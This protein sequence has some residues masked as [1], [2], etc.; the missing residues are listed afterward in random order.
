MSKFTN[1]NDKKIAKLLELSEVVINKQKAAAYVKENMNTIDAI[2]PSDVTTLVHQLVEKGYA[3]EDLKKHIAKILNLFYKALN[4][5]EVPSPEETD[6]LYWLQK[7]NRV[8]QEKLITLKAPIKAINIEGVSEKYLQEINDGIE[9][10]KSYINYFTIKENLLFPAIEKY[11]EDFKCVQVMWSI[12]DDIRRHLKQL[13]EILNAENFDL[14]LFN[15]VSSKL[16]FDVKAIIFR[17]ENILFPEMLLTIPKEDM[18]KFLL[19]SKNFNF[20]FIEPKLENI[21]SIAPKDEFIAG[22]VNLGT[23]NITAEQ[24]IMIFN[25]LPVDITYVDENDTVKFFSTPKHRIFPRTNAI[26]GRKVHNCHPPE[27]VHI[28][29]R[30]VDAFRKGEK[31]EASFWIPMGSKFV[32]IK[33]FAIR[34]NEGAFRGTLEVS[35]EVSDIRSLEGERRLLDWD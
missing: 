25:H 26:I 23:G 15:I 22:Q 3:M 7:N 13:P 31:N 30:I 1:H 9:N 21:A 11:W 27:S 19:E 12:H 2:M 34:D 5:F 33:Y 16:Y 32:L 28:V 20:P 29:E 4:N 24:I 6:L 35:Q 10:L 18:A 14:K 8:M 17:D